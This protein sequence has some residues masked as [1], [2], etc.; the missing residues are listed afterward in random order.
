[1]FIID[2]N[3]DIF[4]IYYYKIIRYLEYKHKINNGELMF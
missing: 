4:E 2:Y 3:I 1:M